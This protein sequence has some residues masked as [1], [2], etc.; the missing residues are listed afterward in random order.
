[1]KTIAL[2][3][4]FVI[5]VGLSAVAG[6]VVDFCDGWEFSRD[7]KEWRAVEIPHDW[8]VEGGFDPEGNP[9]TGKLP[10]KG[11]GYYRKPLF[12]ESVPRDRRIF[13]DFDGVMCDGTVF[14]NGQG[15][16]HQTY[17][18]L[19]MRA[20]VTPYLFQGT[21]EVVVKADTTKLFSRWYPGAGMYRRVRKVET[22]A[23]YLDAS[24][25]VVTARPV[26]EGGNVWSVRVEGFVTSRILRN[27]S[28]KVG[29]V[30][31]SPKGA[32]VFAGEAEA[33]VPMGDK[34]VFSVLFTVRDPELWDMKP[35]APLYTVEVS[36]ASDDGKLR[37]SISVKTG[38][39][40]FR[41]DAKT[42]FYLNGRHVQL[43]GSC[44]H[45]DLGILGMAFN[46]SAMRREL[47]ALMDMGVNAIRTSH[48]P[49]SP[50]LLELCDELGLFVWD[51]CFDKWN[52]TCGRGDEP[53]ETFVEAKLAEFVRRDRNH[54]CVFVWSIGNEI[55]P[56][57]ACPPGQ[58]HW[59]G[60]PALGTTAE[61]CARFRSAIRRH[62]M[63]RPVG[64]GSCFAEAAT[65]GD[66]AP[67]DITGWNYRQLYDKMHELYPEK[68]LI[69]SESASALSDYGH[70]AA[71]LPKEKTDY[72]VKALGVDSYDRNAAVWSDIPDVEFERME[73]DPFVAGE[74]VWTGV[75]YLGEPTPFMRSPVNKVEIPTRDLARSAYFGIYDLLCL[76]K[77]RV[78]LYRSYWRKDAFTLHVVPSHWNFPEKAGKS[79]PVYVYSS[80][81]EVE[82]FLNGVS[83]GRRRKNPAASYQTSYYDVLQRYRFVWE[84]VKYASGEVKAVAYGKDGKA[85]GEEVVRTAGEASAVVLKPE[86][87]V[88]P[89]DPKELVFVAVTLADANGVPVP[90]DNR[91]V[92]FAVEG[93]GE[94]VS[95]GNANPRGHDSFKET[96]SHPLYNGRAGLFIRRTGPG[97]V[98]LSASADG[99]GSAAVRFE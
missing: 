9:V 5:A 59:A 32:T 50:E 82:L 93:A 29:V 69:Y 1:M 10:W 61:R 7:Q 20:D 60:S 16:A 2:T 13:L 86:S 27:A 35:N 15:C 54:P 24:D 92:S 48:N 47:L 34:G 28:A 21:N 19:G 90:R 83:L 58:E 96:A 75:D 12:L 38:F 64:I 53:L 65:K 94:V 87:A 99:L 73:R 71:E 57:K 95:V 36:V 79:I 72:D 23:L 91:R 41:F 78:F 8:A 55:S 77:D 89:A 14:V 80:A 98:R 67:L 52:A 74:F 17:G 6:E 22:D 37:D 63:T 45:S 81:D 4:S 84:D 26:E 30:L 66:Y 44:L 85:L 11:V 97:A 18:Y 56:G 25:L 40:T 88:L 46:R 31:K 43:Y 68:P 33:Q 51:E 49:P 62:D 39:R 42:G 3:L 76:P 70:Y